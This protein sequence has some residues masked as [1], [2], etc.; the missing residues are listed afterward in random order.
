MSSK[1][2]NILVAFAGKPDGSIEL[3]DWRMPPGLTHR[4]LRKAGDFSK[5]SH[6]VGDLLDLSVHPDHPEQYKFTDKECHD[7]LKVSGCINL[8]VDAGR[9]RGGLE[10]VL[11]VN[12]STSC[13]V[14]MKGAL[15][16]GR[17]LLTCKGESKDI[18]IEIERRE[19]TAL[20]VEYDLGNNSDQGNG[21]TTGI[22]ISEQSSTS[23]E[24]SRVRCLRASKPKLL[25]GPFKIVFPK[26]GTWYHGLVVWLLNLVQ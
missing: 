21:T 8:F 22:Q 20:E 18:S 2:D 15:P 6:E 24:V 9:V 10:D 16:R 19:G 1:K 7:A 11:D 26:P 3:V 5:I 25:G 23:A 14:R 4:S 17:F 12:H 13:K